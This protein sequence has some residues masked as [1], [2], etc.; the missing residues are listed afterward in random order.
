MAFKTTSKYYIILITLLLGLSGCNLIV[1]ND[2]VNWATTE[3]GV[4]IDG[5]YH[6]I[7]DNGVKIFLPKDFNRT[8]MANF[9]EILKK[10]IK[11]KAKFNHEINRLNS[12][13]DYG[14]GP[15]HIFYDTISG[16]SYTIKEMEY[17][18]IS[19][20]DAKYLLGLISEGN[21][22]TA[23]NSNLSYEKLTAKYHGSS[24][25]FIF[26][27]IY[28]VTSTEENLNWFNNIYVIT[29]NG[30]TV[31]IHLITGFDVYFDPFIEKTIL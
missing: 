12:L 25:K 8:P 29:Q 24:D 17:A 21:K 13:K 26:K 28:K 23:R 15:L 3:E 22:K 4:Q 10:S 30:K 14:S 16:S 18:P 2:L 11:D 31:L 19:R 27:A 6:F 9:Q 20:N 7:E 1:K 5:T